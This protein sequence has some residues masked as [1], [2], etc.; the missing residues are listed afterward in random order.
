[1]KLEDAVRIEKERGGNTVLGHGQN[2]MVVKVLGIS[3]DDWEPYTQPPPVRNPGTAHPNCH[4]TPPSPQTGA[5]EK[6]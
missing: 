2:G 3:G 6:P 5:G 4:L 1:M